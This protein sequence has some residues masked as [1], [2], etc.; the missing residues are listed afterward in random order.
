MAKS[1]GLG[2]NFY[3]GGYDLS[4]DTASVDEIGG[5]PA[6]ID[7]TGINKSA[8]ERIGGVRDGRIEWTSHFNPS[9]GQ[10]HTALSGL[11]TTD[12][13]VM[14]YRGTTLGVPAAA[15]VGKQLNYDMTRADDGKLSIKVRVDANGFGLEW[16]NSLTAGIRTDTAAAN[17]TGVQFAQANENYVSLPGTAGNYISTPDAASLDITGDI[18]I[19]ARIAAD[20]WTPTAQQYIFAKYTTTGN[21]RSYSLVLDT[22]GALILQ[23]SNDGTTV[24]SKSSTANLSSLANT[25]TKWVRATL[26]VDNGASGNTVTFYTSDDGITWVQLGNAV[27]TAG[28]TSIFSSTAPLEIG[29]H[30]GGTGGNFSGKFFRG[31]I[32]SGIGGTAVAQ[33]IASA[34]TNTVTDATPLTW[35]LNGTAAV[36]AYNPYGAQAYLQVFSLTGTDVTVKI[37]DSADNASF[38]DVAGLAFTQVTSA[39][40]AQRISISNTTTVRRYVRAV[41]TTSGGFTS[42]SFAVVLVANE[43]A[44]T[45]F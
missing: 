5:G 2:D 19:R 33:P 42:A 22:T 11:P 28:T 37:Q 43:T 45:V 7:V 34:S 41:T 35:T 6:L 32:L 18:D 26:D 17:G 12:Q 38:A 10:E 30:T 29:S 9:T 3:V 24:V 39:P 31:S 16:G 25:A 4:G 44:N 23:W 1:S 14:Y 36:S 15:L 21:Q 8:Y 27:V 20:D 40:G 13:Q